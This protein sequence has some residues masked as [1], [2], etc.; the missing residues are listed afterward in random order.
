LPWDKATIHSDISQKTHLA[1]G[2]ITKLTTKPNENILLIPMGKDLQSWS[3][4]EEHPQANENVKY[5]TS[6][7]TQLGVPRMF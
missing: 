3:V 1:I 2:K 6:G 7:K 4:V 5:H